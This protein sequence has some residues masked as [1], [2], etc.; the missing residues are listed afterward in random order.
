M[1]EAM[2]NKARRLWNRLE[3][4]IRIEIDFDEVGKLPQLKQHKINK[5]KSK[6]LYFIRCSKQKHAS[7]R[8]PLG[9]DQ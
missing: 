6:V 1:H 7:K 4:R 9:K 8:E 3:D 5:D 2:Y